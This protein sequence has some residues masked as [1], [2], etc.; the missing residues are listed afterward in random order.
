MRQLLQEQGLGWA[1][2][3]QEHAHVCMVGLCDFVLNTKDGFGISD[4]PYIYGGK[5]ANVTRV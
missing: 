2:L 3:G 5:P 1:G 4:V